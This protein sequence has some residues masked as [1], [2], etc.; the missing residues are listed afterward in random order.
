MIYG[1]LIFP[2]VVK[3]IQRGK[4]YSFQQQ[5]LGQLDIHK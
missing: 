3:T 5:V 4:E 2:K 1:Q